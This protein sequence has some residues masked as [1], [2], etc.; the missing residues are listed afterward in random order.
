[1]LTMWCR[2]HANSLLTEFY[3]VISFVQTSKGW[4]WYFSWIEESLIKRAS[5]LRMVCSQE[6][7]W[8]Y[9]PQNLTMP[10]SDSIIF[11]HFWCMP[12]YWMLTEFASVTIKTMEMTEQFSFLDIE[13]SLFMQNQNIW[14]GSGKWENFIW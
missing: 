7:R 6:G 2:N 4:Q 14:E 1:M 12:S 8:R 13:N 11:W 10:L 9:I 5:H 3:D